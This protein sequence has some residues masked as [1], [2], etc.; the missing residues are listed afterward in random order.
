MIATAFITTGCEV[1]HDEV[2]AKKYVLIA[3]NVSSL[4]CSVIAMGYIVE[5]YGLI[6]TNYHED[7]KKTAD[8]SDYDKIQYRTCGVTQL[9]DGDDGY[10][11][12]AC[13]IGADSLAGGQDKNATIK[14]NHILIVERIDPNVCGKIVMDKIAEDNDMSGD[15]QFYQDNN[16]SC[17]QFDD[18]KSCSTTYSDAITNLQP[19]NATCVV[20]ADKKKLPHT[21]PFSNNF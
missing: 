12:S 8:C 3:Q 16:A 13:A 15:I 9:K 1:S 20:G 2:A 21:N 10:G 4:A 7:P 6:G 17:D 19:G 11:Q 14:K 5:E 18:K